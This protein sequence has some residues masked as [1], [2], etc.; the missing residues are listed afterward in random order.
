MRAVE[1][2]DF[3]PAG[4]ATGVSVSVFAASS[5]VTSTRA[6]P[7]NFSAALLPD[8]VVS[9]GLRTSSHFAPTKT[10]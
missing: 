7:S 10:G 5:S 9:T 3:T 1:R 2:G 6:S 8:I 4:T